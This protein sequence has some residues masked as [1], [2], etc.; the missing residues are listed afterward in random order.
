MKMKF[1]A[2]LLAIAMLLMLTACGGTTSSVAASSSTPE[3]VASSET[4][5]P[6]EESE[7]EAA[8]TALESATSEIEVA[9]AESE[10]MT[11][12]TVI[13]YPLADGEHLS[14]W[15]AKPG[16]PP[17]VRDSWSELEIFQQ[18]EEYLGVT[19]DWTEVDMFAMETQFNLM[20]AAGEYTDIISGVVQNYSTGAVGAYEDGVI[21][22][23][24][25]LVYD[26]MPNYWNL[27]HADSETEKYV[28]TEGGQELAI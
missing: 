18:A 2:M 16:G 15:C 20:M 28:T 12:D 11:N 26:N 17:I 6:L 1:S 9:P 19:I 4:P 22:D 25:D 5:A 10:P 23:I 24:F 21:M 3:A 8:S 7:A 14:I 27:V 13:E